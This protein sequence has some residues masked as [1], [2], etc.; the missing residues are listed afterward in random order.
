[1]D[2]LAD[3]LEGLRLAR[4]GEG[5]PAPIDWLELAAE[6]ASPPAPASAAAIEALR[7]GGVS[8]AYASVPGEPFWSIE[9]TVVVEPLLAR[10]AAL[11][12]A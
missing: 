12:P 7:A 11:W 10:T 6:E 5:C 1:M 8:I 3:G 2:H 9:E 4:L